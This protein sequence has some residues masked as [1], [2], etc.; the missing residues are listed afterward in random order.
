MPT[1]LR[2]RGRL[3]TLLTA[4]AASLLTA[5]VMHIGSGSAST[6]RNFTLRLGDYAAIP[7]LRWTCTVTRY[8]PFSRYPVLNCNKDVP[9]SST[10]EP[11]VW[12]TRR[13]VM[14]EG[15]GS[16]PLRHDRGYDFRY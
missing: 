6:A 9:V 13:A 11:N 5:A 3:K 8:R 7:S 14:V 12:V 4:S 10:I 1:P 16:R 2:S 15:T